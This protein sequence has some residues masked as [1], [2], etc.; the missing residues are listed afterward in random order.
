MSKD[1]PAK[2]TTPAKR[3]KAV[4]LKEKKKKTFSF[5]YALLAMLFWCCCIVVIMYAAVL[6]L[7]GT[8][9]ARAMLSDHLSDAADMTVHV[10]EML[11]G[12][13]IFS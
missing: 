4:A 8:E 12:I 9:G 10:G 11:V 5:S 1:L 13:L 3:S 7:S 6:L 2:K